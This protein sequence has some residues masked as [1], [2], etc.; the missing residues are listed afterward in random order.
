MAYIRAIFFLIVIYITFTGMHWKSNVEHTYPSKSPVSVE[1][2]EKAIPVEPIIE[3]VKEPIEMFEVTAYC[4]CTKCCGP[5]AIGRTKTGTIPK[6][7][8]TIAVDPREIPLGSTVLINGK[9]YI[10]EDIGGAIKGK[11]IDIYFDTHQEAL[12]WG[13]QTCEVQVHGIER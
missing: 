6:A 10:A 11:R 1:N 3:K 9:Q 5:N 12:N 4:A 8:Q 13:R 2:Y 7:N